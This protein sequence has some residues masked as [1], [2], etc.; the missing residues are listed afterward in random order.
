MNSDTGVVYRTQ[1]EINA[2]R[3]RGTAREGKRGC[4]RS[5]HVA[6]EVSRPVFMEA[7]QSRGSAT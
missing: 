5:S 3:A 6:H 7:E 1:E 2:A 4:C